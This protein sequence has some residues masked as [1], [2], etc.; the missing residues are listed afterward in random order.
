MSTLHATCASHTHAQT[1]CSKRVLCPPPRQLARVHHHT[2]LAT[3]S[4]RPKKKKGRRTYPLPEGVRLLLSSPSP[5]AP[6]LPIHSC[7]PSL[8]HRS[9][10]TPLAPRK[11]QTQPSPQPA[12][13]NDS[14]VHTTQTRPIVTPPDTHTTHAIHDGNASI[15]AAVS[16]PCPPDSTATT[17]L[18]LLPRSD[19]LPKSRES[20]NLSS[21]SLLSPHASGST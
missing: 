9:A 20:L 10:C 4:H 19:G 1:S 16:S 8:S 18:P 3:E 11:A 21:Y 17:A 7:P 15:R 13:H 5:H 14:T 12:Q 6:R 2:T